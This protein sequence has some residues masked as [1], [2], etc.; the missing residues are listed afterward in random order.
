M[1][2]QANQIASDEKLTRLMRWR[3]VEELLG[4]SRPTIAR[5][6][7][8]GWFPEPVQVSS[9]VS[10]FLSSEVDAWMQDLKNRRVKH[11]TS[12]YSRRPEATDL[13]ATS[14]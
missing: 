3:E 4:L 1:N 14:A 5:M 2:Q 12:G 6:C 10:A 9:Q 7:A 13:K 8:N 11:Q